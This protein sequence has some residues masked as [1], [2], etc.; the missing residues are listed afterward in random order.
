MARRDMA[1]EEEVAHRGKKHKQMQSAIK[2]KTRSMLSDIEEK[3]S[4]RVD[5]N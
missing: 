5:A 3:L 4:C 2:T 1:G